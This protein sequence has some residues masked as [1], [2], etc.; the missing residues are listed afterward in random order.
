MIEPQAQRDAKNGQDGLSEDAALLVRIGQTLVAEV[1]LD[2]LLQ[3]VTDLATE[4]TDAEF[5]A[6]FFN[7]VSPTGDAYQLYTLSGAP[8]EAFERFGMPRSTQIFRPTFE[9]EGPVR[10]DD[11]RA[12]PRFGQNPPYNGTPPGHLPVV[13]YLA[14]P[15]VSPHGDVRGGLF[16]GHAQPAVFDE[17]AE[18]LAVAVAAFAG[19]AIDNAL[20]HEQSRQAIRGRD[21]FLAAAAHDLRTPL[22]VVSARAQ[23]LG[24]RARAGQLD[25][26]GVEDSVQ[27]IERSIETLAHR[28]EW[29]TD[30][31]RLHAGG[32]LKLELEPVDLA[33]MLENLLADYESANDQHTFSLERS[34]SV[35][36]VTADADRIRRVI[37]NLLNN[38][39]KYSPDGGEIRIMVDTAEELGQRFVRVAVRDPG[40]GIPDDE[41]PRLFEPFHRGRNVPRQVA[42]S[43]IGLATAHRIVA[44][45]GGRIGV[46]SE[47]GAG[48][49]FIVWLPLQNP[50]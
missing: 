48:S 18:H 19:V 28:I 20:V 26:S 34:G 8:K 23:I 46:E 25:P 24:R 21:E 13:S 47:L 32:P 5:G 15:V 49:T 35:P 31:A 2:N 1:N 39:A 38:A 17:R 7:A 4:L 16:F 45:H 41:L 12:D 3:Q 36:T 11:V 9:G 10:L 44:E 14:V 22:T 30:V 27:R 40:I 37:E 50:A 33:S 29:L 43:G 42:G 6:F